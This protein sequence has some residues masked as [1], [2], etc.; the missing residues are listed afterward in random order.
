MPFARILA[1]NP[2]SAR[3]TAQAL[4][5]AGYEVEIVRPGTP[6]TRLADLEFDA[7]TDSVVSENQSFV[8]G[9]REFVLKPLW[10]KLTAKYHAKK[11]VARAERELP[12]AS[13]PLPAASEV[14]VPAPAAA[15]MDNATSQ[16]QEAARAEQQRQQA[17]MQ[18]A[19]AMRQEERRRQEAQEHERLRQQEMARQREEQQSAEIARQKEEA[20]R[21]EMARQREEQ[22]RAEVARQ[23]EEARRLEMARQREA[24]QQRVAVQRMEEERQ[25]RAEVARMEAAEASRQ[26]ELVRQREELRQQEVV[27]RR[28]EEE[29]R[30][31][32]LRQRENEEHARRAEAQRLLLEANLR[33]EESV[34]QRIESQTP[35][36]LPVVTESVP[37]FRQY[38][39]QRVNL[40]KQQRASK[41]NVTRID[42]AANFAWRQAWPITAGVAAAF[43][44]GWG[45]AVHQASKP[46]AQTNPPILSPG[47]YGAY[48]VA[49]VSPSQPVRVKQPAAAQPA[50]KRRAIRDNSVAQDEV[51]TRHY[52]TSK[53]VTAQNGAPPRKKISDLN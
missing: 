41:T 5:Q 28:M 39:G 9:E 32:V 52:Y 11:D 47:Q 12:Q 16:A 31:E 3:D 2:S 18:Q 1:S 48:P 21:L 46:K 23:R 42:R 20:H 50:P 40:W 29:H 51:V 19:A 43:L 13:R 25:Q 26:A 44:L 53:S 14:Q 34:R 30:R 45:V 6:A 4:R 17:A 37:T 24:E 10:R 33:R 36:A 8:P 35:V 49:K 38:L 15:S 27:R 7:D 22:Q